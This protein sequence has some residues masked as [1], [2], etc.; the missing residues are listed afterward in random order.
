VT[1]DELQNAL[2]V[3]AATKNA[4]DVERIIEL[5]SDDCVDH[6]PATGM[7]LEGKEAIRD[8]FTAFFDSVPNYYGEFDGIAFGDDTVVVWGYFG[9]TVS[10]TFLG[11]PIEGVREL[12]VPTA[13]VCRFRDGLL[14]DD[15]QYYDINTVTTQLGLAAGSLVADPREP[16]TL[17]D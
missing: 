10:D 14:V 4:H 16:A 12:R 2:D 9:G 11:V 6:A 13:F 5:R 7:R 3:Y 15:L 1:R 17:A 8:F